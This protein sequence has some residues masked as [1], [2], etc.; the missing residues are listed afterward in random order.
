MTP[1]QNPYEILLPSVPI[2]MTQKL[3]LMKT[4]HRRYTHKQI[5]HFCTKIITFGNLINQLE[6]ELYKETIQ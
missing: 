3:A 2:I 5:N 1:L 4:T 6:F